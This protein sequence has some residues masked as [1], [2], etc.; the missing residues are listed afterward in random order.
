MQDRI[1]EI[2]VVLRFMEKIIVDIISNLNI[3]D[4]SRYST[5]SEKRVKSKNNI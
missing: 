4:M 2:F 5:P 3:R 1:L